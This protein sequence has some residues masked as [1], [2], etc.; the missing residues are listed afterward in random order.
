MGY[1]V[2]S[3]EAAER[4]S[5]P[6]GEADHPRPVARLE[7]FVAEFAAESMEF[8]GE[9]EHVELAGGRQEREPNV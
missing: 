7:I 6:D 9:S 4:G 3:R 5:L 1:A 2:Q 8:F